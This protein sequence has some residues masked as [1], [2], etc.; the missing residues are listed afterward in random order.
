[1]VEQCFYLTEKQKNYFKF[2]FRFIRHY[3]ITYTMEHQKVQN[4]LNETNDSSFVT[5]KQNTVNYRQSNGNYDA[6][7]E[8]IRNTELSE[9]NLFDYSDCCIL[10]GSAISNVGDSGTQVVTH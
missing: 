1:M 9:S 7:N 4:F 6:G 8:I 2:F 3:R 10:A 5:T